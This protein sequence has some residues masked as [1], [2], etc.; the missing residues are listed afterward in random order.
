MPNGTQT[1]A[2]QEPRDVHGLED[3][4]FYHTLDLPGYGHV[5][6][7]W[8]LRGRFDDYIGGVDLRGKTVLTSAPPTAS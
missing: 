6:G 2:F 7:E 8:D 4:Y 3:C 5:Q 1:F